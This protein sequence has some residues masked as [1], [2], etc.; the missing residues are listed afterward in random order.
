MRRAVFLLSLCAL[1][2]LA[3]ACGEREEYKGSGSKSLVDPSAEG[4]VITTSSSGGNDATPDTTPDPG[5]GDANPD[6]L[7][8]DSGSDAKADG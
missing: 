1:L 7:G 2:G 5:T 3:L 6:V 4:G 8:V